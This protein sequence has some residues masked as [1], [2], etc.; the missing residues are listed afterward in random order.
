MHVGAD[1]DTHGSGQGDLSDCH[2][3]HLTALPK[4]YSGHI[5][6]ISV[7]SQDAHS[8]VELVRIPQTIQLHEFFQHMAG[9]PLAGTTQTDNQSGMRNS[10]GF[11]LL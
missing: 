5:L 1:G 8:R 6:K 4:A 3:S 2:S 9:H 7:H 11:A 10:H